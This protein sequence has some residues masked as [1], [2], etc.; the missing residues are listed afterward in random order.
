MDNK[1]PGAVEHPIHSQKE[2]INRH[3]AI[4]LPAR[5]L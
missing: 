2:T 3:P 5:T 4:H 1:Q